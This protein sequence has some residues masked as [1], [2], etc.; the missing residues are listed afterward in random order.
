MRRV[1]VGFFRGRGTFAQPFQ[2][3]AQAPQFLPRFEHGAV[4]FGDV[5]FEPGKP[6]FQRAQPVFGHGANR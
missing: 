5:A 6:C 2:L 4:L 3:L 1:F